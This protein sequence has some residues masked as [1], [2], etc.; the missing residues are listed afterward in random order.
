MMKTMLQ[1]IHGIANFTLLKNAISHVTNKSKTAVITI[2]VTLHIKN[3]T[4]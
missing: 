3:D 1:W 2:A 4:T